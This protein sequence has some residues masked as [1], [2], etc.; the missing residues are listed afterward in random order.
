MEVLPQE[1]WGTLPLLN[2]LITFISWSRKDL[3]FASVLPLTLCGPG[4][5]ASYARFALGSAKLY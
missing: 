4:E 5:L 3:V 1:V 2:A